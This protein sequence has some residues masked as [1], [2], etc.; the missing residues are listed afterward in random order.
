MATNNS[1][2]QDYKNNADGFELAGGT[3]K[4][5]LTVQSGDI[6]VYGSPAA[7]TLAGNL[8][9]AGTNPLTLT[10]TGST[11]VTLP[12]SGT[13]SSLAGSEDL[14][15][16]TVVTR[17]GTTGLAPLKLTTGSLLTSPAA[18]AVEFNSDSLY[19]TTTT[20]PTRRRV[21][22]YPATGGA[23]GDVYYRDASGNFTPLAV[24]STGNVLTAAS[25]LPAWGPA[26]SPPVYEW[27]CDNPANWSADLGY[28]IELN[29]TGSTLPSG[30]SWVN[31]GS[32]TWTEAFGAGCLNN[33]TGAGNSLR[34]IVR[35]FP[36]SASWA[37]TAKIT[38]NGA[39]LN[40]TAS[41][42]ILRSSSTGRLMVL[43]LQDTVSVSVS[44]WADTATP[45]TQHAIQTCIEPARYFRI[46]R[47][48]STSYTYQWS[49]D[50]A[51]W[52]T[53]L[54]AHNPT[55]YVTPDQIGFYVNRPTLA[56]SASGSMHWFRIR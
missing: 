33:V 9:T 54:S 1:S 15:N 43:G 13:L 45:S 11:N 35:A 40:G 39:V 25:G 30:W 48:S 6:A 27:Y 16:K 53:L 52:V 19:I 42:L 47:N 55:G 3:A 37:A 5:K 17:A 36:P 51:G 23:T 50:G 12:T 32:T 44:Q 26:P 8:S 34:G 18:G 7:L 10:T 22:A 28:D 56:S 29:G 38:L 2:N 14:T 49:C 24:G 4:R 20:G 21:A 46:T 41:G 31:Q